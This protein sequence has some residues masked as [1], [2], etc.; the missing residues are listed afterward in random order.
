MRKEPVPSR[1]LSL[2]TMS[3]LVIILRSKIMLSYRSR[4]HC[5]SKRHTRTRLYYRNMAM[6]SSSCRARSVNWR[7][8]LTLKSRRTHE[9]SICQLW[10]SKLNTRNIATGEIRF[11]SMEL[12]IKTRDRLRWPNRTS[13][14]MTMRCLCTTVWS[15]Q[16]F[17]M[18][19]AMKDRVFNRDLVAWRL[20]TSSR[21][22]MKKSPKT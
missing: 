10:R 13:D 15:Q 7:T 1:M 14:W 22:S 2:V 5:M 11:R 16:S 17:K 12:V 21:T 18:P 20:L 3:S 19:Q 6:W 9:L 4:K 8:N